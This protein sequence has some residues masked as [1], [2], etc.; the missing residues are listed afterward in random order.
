MT[1]GGRDLLSQCACNGGHA[2]AHFDNDGAGAQT[3]QNAFRA[4]E[5]GLN[6]GASRQDGDDDV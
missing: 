2:R 6:D 3:G 4:V 5:D 1:L